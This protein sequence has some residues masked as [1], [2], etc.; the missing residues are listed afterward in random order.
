MS[1]SQL[2]ILAG[3]FAVL[4]GCLII[5]VYLLVT[6]G[7]R[8]HTPTDG[9]A[10]KAEP[11]TTLVASAEPEPPSNQTA[12]NTPSL[13]HWSAVESTNYFEY[14]ANLRRIGCPE[15]TIADIV[16]ADL[17]ALYAEATPAAQA[18]SGVSTGEKKADEVLKLL[19]P[20]A[21]THSKGDLASGQVQ[22]RNGAGNQRS[23]LNS[24]AQTSGSMPI[25]ASSSAPAPSG[26]EAVEEAPQAP[27]S[28]R[29]IDP[30]RART[31]WIRDYLSTR[32]GQSV[33][34]DASLYS[35]GDPDRLEEILAFNNI[36]VPEPPARNPRR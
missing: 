23:A 25:N 2:K 17:R 33:W 27:G 26:Q 4:N 18:V 21:T 28:R 12:A 29:E 36:T 3:A 8:D 10:A 7:S 24:I 31:F 14:V 22:T 30:V 32:Y 5:V 11:T 1:A 20:Q 6:S 19:V 9:G 34:N 35:R 16:A 13:L 15:Q